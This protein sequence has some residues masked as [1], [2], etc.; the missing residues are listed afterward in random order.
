MLKQREKLFFKSK[1]WRKKK[2][3]FFKMKKGK[4]L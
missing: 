1:F 4:I 2:F 3:I